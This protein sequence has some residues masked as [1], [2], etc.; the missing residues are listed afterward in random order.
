MWILGYF[1]KREGTAA[2][3]GGVPNIPEPPLPDSGLG[4]SQGQGHHN[5]R[6][7]DSSII[8]HGEKR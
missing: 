5:F 3:P 1:P 8:N 6:Q 2:L 4:T 7:C